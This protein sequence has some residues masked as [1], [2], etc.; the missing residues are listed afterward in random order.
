MRVPVAGEED[1]AGDCV[2]EEQPETNSQRGVPVLFSAADWPQSA[3]GGIVSVGNFD[4]VHRGHAWLLQAMQQV[5]DEDNAN[6]GEQ[7]PRVCLV[8]YPHPLTLL[9]PAVAPTPLS[10]LEERASWLLQSGATHVLAL[11]PTRELLELSAT[12]FFAEYLVERGKI[13]GIIEGENFRFGRHRQGNTELLTQLC[14]AQGIRCQILPPLLLE[15]ILNSGQVAP[16]AGGSADVD[17]RLAVVSSSKI[18]ECLTAGQIETANALLGRP[19]AVTGRVGTGAQRGRLLGFPTANLDQVLTL[20]P[21][22]G[23]YAGRVKICGSDYLAAIHLGYNPTF[24]EQIHKLEVHVLD[25]HGDLYG[26]SLR[27]EFWHQLRR[28]QT[29]DSVD[30]LRDQLQQDIAQVR[31]RLR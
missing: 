14:R 9:R 30:A 27:V 26:Q 10:V 8:F 31:I 20:V 25:W 3:Q 17:H 1:T 29:F 6:A 24:G 16:Q 5:A 15:G 21:G 7:I 23:V 28:V 13:R 12:E 4:G 18:R 19:Y 22:P 2:T 11:P